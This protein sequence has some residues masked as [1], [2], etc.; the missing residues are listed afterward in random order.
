MCLHSNLLLTS[1]DTI[2]TSLKTTG[3]FHSEESKWHRRGI[4][5]SFPQGIRADTWGWCLQEFSYKPVTVHKIK[6]IT[7]WHFDIG[8]KICLILLYASLDKDEKGIKIDGIKGISSSR[9]GVE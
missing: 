8:R 5:P 2:H 9:W 1:S 6:D 4:S 3:G 7:D